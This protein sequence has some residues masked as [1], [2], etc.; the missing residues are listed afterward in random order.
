MTRNQS[1]TIIAVGG[2]LLAAVCAHLLADVLHQPPMPEGEREPEREVE[3]RIVPRAD[4]HD[5]ARRNAN[6]SLRMVS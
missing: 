4:A 5:F 6:D 2:V 3:P 1:L